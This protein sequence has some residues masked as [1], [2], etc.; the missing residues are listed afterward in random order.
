MKHQTERLLML[1]FK[2]SDRQNC[3]G[4]FHLPHKLIMRKRPAHH[5]F[6]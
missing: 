6:F 3:D 1:K 5:L 2:A 4:I